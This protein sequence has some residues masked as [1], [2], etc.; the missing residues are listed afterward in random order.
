VSETISNDD[1]QGDDVRR[2]YISKSKFLWGLQCPKLLW[3][4]YHAK[5]LIPE[6]DAAQ[7]AVF[8]QGHEVG[9]L[10]KQLYPDGIEITASAT[11]LDE[12]IRQTR[13]ALRLRRPL[14]EAAFE[15]NRG[16][17][18][19]DILVPV[20]EDQWDIVEVKSTTS[21]KDVHIDD[22]AFQTWV[23]TQA[24]LQVRRCS[25]L[26]INPDFV[27]RGPIDSLQFFQIASSTTKVRQP[28]D[29]VEDRL[30]GML[31]AISL[32]ASPEI[33]IGPH[34]DDPYTC[35]LHAYSGGCRTLIPISVGQRS[36]F[37]RTP[38]RFISDSVPG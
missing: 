3:T 9:A 38:F 17:T 20:G 1:E 14:F 8:D 29:Q 23:L 12:T 19:T 4:A 7:Q 18:R 25:V 11:D 27:R 13:Q 36:D 21:L 5:H 31:R 24:G 32:P 10:A 6:P 33:T 35:P 28:F 37:S 34:C 2:F 26:H 15:P 30:A 22:L 16:Y